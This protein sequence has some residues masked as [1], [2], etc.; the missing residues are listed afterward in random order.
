MIKKRREQLTYFYLLSDILAIVASFALTFFLR[1]YSGFISVPKGVPHYGKYFL[2]LPFLIVVQVFYFSYMGYYRIKLRRNRLDDLFLVFFNTVLSAIVILLLFSYLRSYEHVDFQVSHIF[3]ILYIPFSV[4]IIFGFRL[5]VFSAFKKTF[6]KNNGISRVLIAGTGD[7]AKMMGGN[8]ARYNHFGID[9][10]G[11]LS[12]DGTGEMVL[13][14]YSDVKKVVKEH[15]ITDIFIALSMKN[16]S[17]ITKLI[18]EGNNLLIDV[19]L[20]PDIVHMSSLGSGMEHIEGLPV[21]NL[22]DIRLN[23]WRLFLKNSFDLIFGLVALIIAIIP[24]IGISIL[25]KIS[26]KGPVLYTQSRVG[27]SGKVFN[28]IK[29]R[30]MI[31]DAEKNTGAIWSPPDDNR[32]TKIGKVLRKFSL[33]ELPQLIN[34]IK[35]E[36]SLI[37][38][39]PERPELVEKFKD[40]IPKYMLRHTVKPGM[41]GWAQVHGLRGNTPLNKRIEFDI[42][43]IQNW[44]MKIDFEILWRTVLKFQFIDVN[45]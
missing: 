14:K 24:M 38:P 6:L 30:T 29:F 40:E 37:G 42:F 44:S 9:V 34:V 16:F 36:M 19:K 2:V 27:V 33:D 4:L 5:A 17:T 43:Y 12:D 3:L 23:G 26:S 7:I 39:R 11:Y 41:T 25:I 18:E 8:L 1:F 45:S 21:I 20:V 10:V 35:G 32:V 31:Q 28:I 15:G 13:G 22:G